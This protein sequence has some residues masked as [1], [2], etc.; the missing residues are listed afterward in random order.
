MP[1]TELF[2]WRF[3]SSSGNTIAVTGT[4]RGLDKFP[5]R[6]RIAFVFW[7]SQTPYSYIT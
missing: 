2:S 1:I 7:W 5:F 6:R 3:R 4:K